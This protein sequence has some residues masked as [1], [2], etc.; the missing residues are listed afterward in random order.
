MN[1]GDATGKVFELGGLVATVCGACKAT[2]IHEDATTLKPWETDD[3]AVISCPECGKPDRVSA[4]VLSKE[5]DREEVNRTLEDWLLR[6]QA[7]HDP[8]AL[9]M[10][11][12]YDHPKDF[13]GHYVV[14]RWLVSGANV[15]VSPQAQLADSLEDA[16]KLIPFGKVMLGRA[17]ED[18]PVIAEIWL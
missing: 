1:I 12:I 18:D 2:A 7:E 5:Q 15:M 8:D 17:P 6:E 14:R 13:P 16:R 11:V 4:F 3:P 10:F 9:R